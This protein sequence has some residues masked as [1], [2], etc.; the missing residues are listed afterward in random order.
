MAETGAEARREA[1]DGVLSRDF[2]QYFRPLL[3]SMNMLGLMKTDSGM[4]DSEVTP[5]YLVDNIWVV[6]SPDDVAEKLRRLHHDVGGFGV[7]LAM[8]HEWQPQDRWQR[9]MTLLARDVMSQLSD[10]N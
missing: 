9:S 1:L 4:A 7:L 6:G 10:L 8:A 3:S 5:E 2:Q